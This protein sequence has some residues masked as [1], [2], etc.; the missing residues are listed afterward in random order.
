MDDMGVSLGADIPDQHA[1]RQRQPATLRVPD[2]RQLKGLRGVVSPSP[3]PRAEAV[4]LG[5]EFL[6]QIF[7]RSLTMTS[8]RSR[9]DD[10]LLRRWRATGRAPW[11]L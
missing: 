1:R 3:G 4:G 2:T 11:S 9:C 5:R 6:E 8:S 7:W 10:A